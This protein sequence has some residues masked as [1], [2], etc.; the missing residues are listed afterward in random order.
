[1][2]ESTTYHFDGLLKDLIAQLTTLRAV[3][4]YSR[5]REAAHLIDAAIDALEVA[6]PYPDF[7]AEPPTPERPSNSLLAGPVA[8]SKRRVRV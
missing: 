4:D 5:L 7:E 6:R 8:R 2:A 3:A 1:M